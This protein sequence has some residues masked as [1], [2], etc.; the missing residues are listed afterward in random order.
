MMIR[1]VNVIEKIGVLGVLICG[2]GV[3]GPD[4]LK[5][6]GLAVMFLLIA[7]AGYTVEYRLKERSERH[8]AAKKTKQR[9]KD[10]TFEVWLK[11]CQLDVPF[12]G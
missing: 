3:G 2:A 4:S 8:K 1:K 12:R 5:C 10:V 7:A 6:L 9:T 11:S